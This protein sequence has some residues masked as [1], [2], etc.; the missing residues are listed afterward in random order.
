MIESAAV[1]VA[2]MILSWSAGVAWGCYRYER[3]HQNRSIIQLVKQ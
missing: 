3:T 1:L 2:L